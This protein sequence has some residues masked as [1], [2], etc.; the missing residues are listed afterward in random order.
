MALFETVNVTLALS[1]LVIEEADD[2]WGGVEAYVVPVFYKVDGERYVAT[3]RILNSLQPRLGSTEVVAGSIQFAVD[4]L[5]DTR[6]VDEEGEPVIKEDN[7][8]TLCATRQSPG[9]R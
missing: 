1:G 5:D 7:P 4:T 9:A 3:L 8:L 2:R 6:P